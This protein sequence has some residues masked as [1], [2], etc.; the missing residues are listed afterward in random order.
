VKLQAWFD[1]TVPTTGR[2]VGALVYDQWLRVR[3]GRPAEVVPSPEQIRSM[4]HLP[5]RAVFTGNYYAIESIEV[6]P[7]YHLR[8]RFR[9]GEVR[10]ADIKAMRG[11]SEF[12]QVFANFE[13]A[14]NQTY[15]VEWPVTFL[16]GPNTLEIE[17]QDLWGA[18]VLI[19]ST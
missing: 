2:T 9:N 1:L 7:D 6:F 14:V 15:H 13:A 11:E 16:S 5:T 3:N 18:G 8:I 19:A 10:I 17:D 12:E 4:D